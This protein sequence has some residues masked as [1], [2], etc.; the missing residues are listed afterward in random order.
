MNMN[1]LTPTQQLN[2]KNICLI[3]PKHNSTYILYSALNHF[4]L[5]QRET[6]SSGGKFKACVPHSSIV[7]GL[8]V[9]KVQSIAIIF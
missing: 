9:L 8:K 4:T 6:S 1:G 5:N 3:C 7:T 2:I